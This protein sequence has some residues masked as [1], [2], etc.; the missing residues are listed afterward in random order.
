MAIAGFI[1]IRNYL[2]REERKQLSRNLWDSKNQSIK[3][4]FRR[5]YSRPRKTLLAQNL[6]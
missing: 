3:L 6:F 4:K 2:E 5:K 1:S